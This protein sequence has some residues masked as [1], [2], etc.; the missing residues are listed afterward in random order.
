MVDA[1]GPLL[2]VVAHEDK[3]FFGT[4][5][6]SFDEAEDEAAATVI[7]SVQRLVKDEK[8]GVFDEG[9]SHKHQTLLAARHFQERTIGQV[10][11]AEEAHPPKTLLAFLGGGAYV[12]S[13]GVLQTAG[14]DV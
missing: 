3:C 7:E 6:K 11:D 12:E 2:A 1:G 10:V 9:A 4:A 8:V 13:H 14:Y 5:T